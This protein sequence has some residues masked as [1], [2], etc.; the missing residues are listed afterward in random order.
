[1]LDIDINPILLTLGPFEIR[2]YGVMVVL[3]VIAIISI[4]LLEARRK[5]MEPDTVWDVALWGVIGGIIGARVLH[6]IDKWDYYFAHPEQFLNFAGLAVWGS[7]LGAIVALLIYCAVKKIS[8]WVLGDLVAP[9]AI[10]GQAIGRVGCV[11]N[12]CC[13]GLPCELPIAVI[14]LNPDSYAPQG[15]PLYPTQI[16]HIVW[17]LAGFGAL[18]LLRKKLRLDGALFLVWLI[19]FGAGDFVIRFFRE[20]EPFLFNLPQAQFIDIAIIV[21][22]AILLAVKYA[23]YKKP[24]PAAEAGDVNKNGQNPAG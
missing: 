7:V 1:M 2:W 3:A 19:I 17:N 15:V 5:K 6:I 23:R 13:Y 12:G 24:L 16:F 10:M 18:W 4:S 14:Y 22:A 8:F 20:G 11:I 21:V 9:G